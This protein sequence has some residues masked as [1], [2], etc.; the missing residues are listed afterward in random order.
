MLFTKIE[1]EY[2]LRAAFRV[3][4]HDFF[5]LAGYRALLDLYDA[6]ET[7]LDIIS[8]CCDYTEARYDTIA[9]DYEIDLSPAGGGEEAAIDLVRQ[10][11]LGHTWV[12]ETA[13]GAF[14][15]Q[16]F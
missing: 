5:S 15:Y 9:R 16:R 1:D 10:Y 6:G 12:T 8:I 14:L 11:L 7:E 2:E 4:D 3:Y 13:D